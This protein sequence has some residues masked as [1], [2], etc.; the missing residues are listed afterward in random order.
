M[1]CGKHY[2]TPIPQLCAFSCPIT[3][4]VFTDAARFAK[5]D[6]RRTTSVTK[7]LGELDWPVLSDRR[8]EARLSVFSKAAGGHSAISL[9]HLSQPTRQTRRADHTSFIPI[10]ARTD[11]YKYSFFP[12]TLF[13]WNTLPAEI[14]LKCS[15]SA[16]ESADLVD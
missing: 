1:S 7:L 4:L 2:I 8:R 3:S 15:L 9:S 6:Y 14:R 5:H 11:V 16:S 12:C 10:S 13:D